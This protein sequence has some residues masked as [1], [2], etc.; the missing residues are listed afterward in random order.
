MKTYMEVTTSL[1]ISRVIR[2]EFSPQQQTPRWL[3]N[4]A[5]W[6]LFSEET[7]CITEVPDC[8]PLDYYNQITEK[9]IQGAEKSIPKSNGFFKV[10]PVPWWNPTCENL[11]KERLK[12]QRKMIRHPTVT[13]R[14]NYKRMRAKF[15][16]AQKD[17]QASSWKNYVSTI[18]SRTESA[19]VWKRWPRLKVITSPNHLP[20]LR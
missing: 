20:P 10:A 5:N 9:I 19:K 2:M 12:A 16:R 6:E 8:S 14:S 18:N 11:K 1:C 3:T 7:Q 4:K 17:T 13:N 15:Q